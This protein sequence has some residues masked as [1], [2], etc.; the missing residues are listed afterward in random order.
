MGTDLTIGATTSLAAERAAAARRGRSLQHLTIAWNSAECVVALVAGFLAGSI[1]L[2]GF[3]FDSAIEVTSSVAALQRLRWDADETRRE[4][5]G[6]RAGRVSG[7]CLLLL[8]A[9]IGYDVRR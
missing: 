7:A 1:A 9:D 6:R 8:A 5:A 3:G 2:V 4:A